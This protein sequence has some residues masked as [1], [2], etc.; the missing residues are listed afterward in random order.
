MFSASCDRQRGL[1]GPGGGGVG[2]CQIR[3]RD[4]D[5]TG[6]LGIGLKPLGGRFAGL[7]SFLEFL[8]QV[9]V[10]LLGRAALA[11][12]DH[13]LRAGV[14]E[15]AFMLRLDLSGDLDLAQQLADLLADRCFERGR[16][17]DRGA[18]ECL[19]FAM[20]VD[21]AFQGLPRIGFASG[22]VR[23]IG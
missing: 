11:G 17:F 22:L 8:A 10:F 1:D 4:S 13:E 15:R 5:E 2:Q 21:G 3:H 7:S 6:V 9:R 16:R 18:Q 12:H 19:L 14:F 23:E 20:R